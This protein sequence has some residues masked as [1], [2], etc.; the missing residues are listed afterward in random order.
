[1]TGKA[2]TEDQMVHI[3]RNA[4]IV[5]GQ[6][7]GQD[8]DHWPVI[9]ATI[10]DIMEDIEETKAKRA[11]LIQVK[12]Y[13]EDMIRELVSIRNKKNENDKAEMEAVISEI[14]ALYRACFDEVDLA[15]VYLSETDL[16]QHFKRA[17]III[18]TL[19]DD[20]NG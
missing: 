6:E 1:M 5:A 4:L 8:G 10:H 9:N 13:Y 20:D 18:S 7:M 2:M 3:V 19:G 11:A 12:K 14:R 16:P 17:D 15:N